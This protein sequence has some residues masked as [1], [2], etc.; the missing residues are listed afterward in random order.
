MDVSVTYRRNY[1]FLAQAK[2]CIYL[3]FEFCCGGNLASF[4]KH[5]GRVQEHI[6]R[7]FM[8]QLGTSSL[9]I[10][11]LVS[12]HW[13]FG[14]PLKIF[15]FPFEIFFAG[16]GLEVLHSHH[17]IHRDLKPEVLEVFN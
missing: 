13:S 12:A 17:M 5:T 4:I 9:S 10:C 11:R 1:C 2:G 8:Q 16:A 15:W 14:F 6:A 7:R 3:V